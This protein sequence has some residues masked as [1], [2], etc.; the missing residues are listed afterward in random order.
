[1]AAAKPTSSGNSD[2][3]LPI[4]IGVTVLLLGAAVWLYSINQAPPKVEKPR[5]VWLSV[6]KVMAQMADGRMVNVKVNLHL[7]GQEAVEELSGHLPAFKALIQEVGTQTS[8][9]DMKNREGMMRFADN[10]AESLNDY[11]D[12]QRARGYIEDVAL[13][14]LTLLP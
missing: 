11:L 1:M 6:P 2:S 14:E 13:E 5:P 7:D 9:E 12:E 8:R 4:L 3:L 10:I